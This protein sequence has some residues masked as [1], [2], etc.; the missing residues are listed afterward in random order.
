MVWIKGT[1]KFY[2]GSDDATC[3]Q[4]DFYFHILLSVF[5][6]PKEDC[7]NRE[8]KSHK[9]ELVK[10]GIIPKRHDLQVTYPI[11]RYYQ[12]KSVK[13]NDKR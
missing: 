9:H 6:F 4:N 1:C 7:F 11:A 3:R 2:Y 5:R 8:C 12:I 13:V 10:R